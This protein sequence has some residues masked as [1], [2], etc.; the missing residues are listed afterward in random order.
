MDLKTLRRMYANGGSLKQLKGTAMA[1]DDVQ[2][3]LPGTA[4][5][6]YPELAKFDTLDQLLGPLRQAVILYLI[7]ETFGHFTCIFRRG[8]DVEVFDSYGIR[9]DD[10]LK[11]ISSHFRNISEQRAPHLSYLLYHCPYKI[12]FNDHKLQRR[13]ASVATCGPHCIVRLAFKDMPCDSYAAMLQA[14][15]DPDAVVAEAVLGPH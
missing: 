15:G 11:F 5:L 4:V 9:P 3:L 8:N 13:A 10:E 14:S 12:H 1:M 6:T 2:K 7:E